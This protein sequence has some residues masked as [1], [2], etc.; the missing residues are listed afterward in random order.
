MTKYTFPPYSDLITKVSG[1]GYRPILNFEYPVIMTGNGFVVA[2]IEKRSAVVRGI[3]TRNHRRVKINATT[4]QIVPL[5]PDE[6]Q[7]YPVDDIYSVPPTLV[8]RGTYN[9][10][11]SRD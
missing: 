8:L 1:G 11:P 2:K 6:H 5:Q 3:Y 7:L 10:Q 4:G 9:N